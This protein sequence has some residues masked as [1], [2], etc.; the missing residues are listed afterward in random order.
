[1]GARFNLSTDDDLLALFPRLDDIWPR[2]NDDGS[3]RF[4]WSVHH[5]QAAKFI[6][7][8]L[9]ATKSVPER[10]QMGRLSPRSKEDLR[11]AAAC[12]ALSFIFRSADTQGDDLGYYDR[13]AKYFEHRGIAALTDASMLLDYDV[14]NS[15]D[16][17]AAELQ[18][19]FPVRLVRG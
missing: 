16:F 12:L 7:R 13:N 8:R 19:P 5:D 3:A 2:Q 17:G 9:R 10:F 6:E 15:G 14:D 4:D 18:Q 1:M 11:E